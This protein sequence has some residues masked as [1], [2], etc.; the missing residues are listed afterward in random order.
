MG[1]HASIQPTAAEQAQAEIG[2]QQMADWQQRWA[3]I[4]KDFSA[5]TLKDAAPDSY[6]R[7]HASSMAGADTAV[8]FARAQDAALRAQS[9]QGLAGS[10]KQKLA[11]AGLTQDQATS[12][13]FGQVA[14]DQAVD[15][16][17]TQGLGTVAAIGAGQKA[18]A[19]QGI[20]QT[21]QMSAQ[22]AQADADAALANRA[23]NA[24]LAGT[25]IGAGL[26]L[27]Q[28]TPGAAPAVGLGSNP[29]GFNGTLNNPSAFVGGG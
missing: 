6:A 27:W 20:N 14:A 12:G 5:Q 4:I 3:P 19:M 13:A 16:A 21:A 11:L 28:G 24:Q 10:A 9:Q 7:R 8:G 15:D 17:T 1:K 22:Q 26:G 18:T 29:A 2:A 23:G 25:V